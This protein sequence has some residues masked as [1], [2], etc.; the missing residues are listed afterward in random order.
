MT[1]TCVVE[2]PL[3]V[4][5][6]SWTDA[7]RLRV[8]SQSLGDRRGADV[9]ETVRSAGAIQAQDRLGELLGVGVRGTGLSAGD[10]LRARC[11][12][13]TVARS[14]LMRGTLH[15][16]PS[17]DLRWMLELLGPSMDAKALKR[18]AGLGIDDDSHG[19][20]IGLIRQAVSSQGPMTRSEIA[21]ALRAAELPW[22]GQAT[23]HLLRSASLLGAVCFGPD[24]DGE[25]THVALDDWLPKV[26]MAPADT[27]AELARRFFAAY[28][29]ATA[30][31]LRWWTGLPAAEMRRALRS[32]AG[33][34]VELSIEGDS[35]WMTASSAA[36]IDDVLAAPS[37]Q[38]R[39]VGPFD[40]YLLGYARRNLG[41]DDEALKQ[42][43]AGGGMIRSCVLVD[44]RLVGT[45]ER[46]RRARGYAVSVSMLDAPSNGWS[47]QLDLEFG[48]IGRFLNLQVAWT[49]HPSSEMARRGGSRQ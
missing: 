47:D 12:E 18:R 30:S 16:V 32:I 38:L 19:R 42:V 29:P 28:G 14:W 48:E 41:V 22:D 31:D 26:R 13:R 49:L 39:V 2:G 15:L 7:R 35:M 9:L 33:E 10:V 27:S 23:P 4:R 45:W 5:E 40:P 3:E 6:L 44:G 46:K 11:E 1:S 21:E 25:S 37:D 20:A 34:L 24:R 36:Q 17:D 43:N 8:A